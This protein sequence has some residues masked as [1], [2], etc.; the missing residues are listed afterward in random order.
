MKYGRNRTVKDH[1][2]DVQKHLVTFRNGQGRIDFDRDI[3]GIVEGRG[4]R[5]SGLVLEVLQPENMEC[6]N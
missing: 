6:E 4:E 5:R 3:N 2:L 1:S